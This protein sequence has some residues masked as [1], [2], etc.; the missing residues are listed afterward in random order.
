MKSLTLNYKIKNRGIPQ[1][2]DIF[3]PPLKMFILRH[4]K[5]VNAKVV[6]Y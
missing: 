5:I 2:P 3:L 4:A 6:E 1:T